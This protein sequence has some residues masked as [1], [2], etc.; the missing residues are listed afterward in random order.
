MK[1]PKSSWYGDVKNAVAS[2]S[3]E[4]N[5]EEAPTSNKLGTKLLESP[6]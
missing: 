5:S 1:K 6:P 3:P 4:E 2:V